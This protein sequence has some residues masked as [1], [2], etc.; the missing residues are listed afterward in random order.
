MRVTVVDVFDRIVFVK[1][2]IEVQVKIVIEVRI[3][4]L[5][6]VQV[7]VVIEVRIRA[8]VEVQV[9]EL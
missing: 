2:L 8:L 3:K 7:K 6:E 5:I 4:A 1:A 9:K